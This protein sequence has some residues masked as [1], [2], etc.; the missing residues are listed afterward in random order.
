MARS[1]YPTD[2]D[3]LEALGALPGA[4]STI[5]GYEGQ[6]E[7]ARIAFEAMTGWSLQGSPSSVY[8]APALTAQGVLAMFDRPLLIDGSQTVEAWDYAAGTGTTLTY[9][10][11]F[12]WLPVKVSPS[13]AEGILAIS[14]KAASL[15]K[16]TG[17]FGSSSTVLED[18]WQAVLAKAMG[19]SLRIMQAFQGEITE[20]KTGDVA[21]KF[22]N[23]VTNSAII[24]FNQLFQSTVRRY[25]R[26]I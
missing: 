17:V 7:A 14:T 10:T 2:S 25:T 18:I 16:I 22:S 13:L 26:I 6:A 4:P 5:A 24:R 20:T 21:I 15:L 23:S 3:V 19:E 12:E 8:V 1:S 9:K 11:D